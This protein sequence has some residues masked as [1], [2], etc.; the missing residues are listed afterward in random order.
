MRHDR[1]LPWIVWPAVIGFC[2][3]LGF[4]NAGIEAIE[5]WLFRS[6]IYAAILFFIVFCIVGAGWERMSKQKRFEAT[7]CV[8]PASV[9]AALSFPLMVMGISICAIMAYSTI[10]DLRRKDRN[11]RV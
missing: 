11:P 2:L 5:F 3:I 7:F 6:L 10:S 9:L 1:K 4:L 8:V